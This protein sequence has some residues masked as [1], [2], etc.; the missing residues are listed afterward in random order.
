MMKRNERMKGDLIA[1]ALSVAIIIAST[2]IV[3]NTISPLIRSGQVEQSFND[4]KQVLT[5]IDSVANEIMTEAPG[6]KRSINFN[7]QKGKL[8][9]NGRE[10]KIKIRIEDVD[11]LE[12]GITIEESNILISGGAKINSY[13]SDIEGDGD[14]DLVLENAAVLFAVQ[15]IGSP[16]AYATLNT[17]TMITQI[18]NIRTGINITPSSGI[19]INDMTNTSYGNGFTEMTQVSDADSRGIRVFVNSSSGMQYEALFTL[20]AA[21][22]FVDLQ[23][24][25][26]V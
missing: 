25:R 17:S 26:I 23:V 15:K 11:I 6:S 1:G 9:V 10:D 8:I 21:K 3:V 18:K 20:Q 4:A 5:S 7:L 2:I 19:F 14:T 16:S 12:A 22:D 13:E 24:K